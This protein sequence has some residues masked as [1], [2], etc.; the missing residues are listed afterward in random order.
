MDIQSS[1][2]LLFAVCVVSAL[3]NIAAA[4]DEPVRE[5]A[6]PK[7]IAEFDIAKRGDVIVL[8]VTIGDRSYRF[9]L[10]VASNRTTVDSR[11]RSL[12]GKRIE[13]EREP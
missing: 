8:P 1:S 5:P 13:P 2:Q 4:V 7:V 11:L 3:R 12:L 10:S 6:P 9:L